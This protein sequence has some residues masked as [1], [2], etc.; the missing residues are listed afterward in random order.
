VRPLEAIDFRARDWIPHSGWPLEL[1]DLAPYYASA[2]AFLHLSPGAFDLQ[3]RTRAIELSPWSFDRDEVRSLV[4][5]IVD[6]KYRRFGDTLR[7]PV[8]AAPNIHTYLHANALALQPDPSGKR[9]AGVAT[10]TLSGRRLTARA[11]HYVLAAG[12]IENAR[13]LLLSTERGLGNENDL[14]GRFF[15]NHLEARVGQLVPAE[16]ERAGFYWKRPEGLGSYAALRLA[17]RIQTENKLANCRF[18]VWPAPL[19]ARN[20]LDRAIARTVATTDAR[21][22]EGRQKATRDRSLSPL[23]LHL[24]AEPAPNPDSRVT[25]GDERDAFDQRKVVLDWRLS[26]ADSTRVAQSL[27]RLALAVGASAVGRVHDLFPRDGFRS[28]DPRG[29]FHHM[30]T[31]RMHADAKR[32]VVDAQCRLHATANLHVAGSSV[33]PTFG[34][35]NPTLTILALAFRLADRLVELLAQ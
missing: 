12:G 14:V 32:G 5:R 33:F 22:V 1:A 17:D 34:T 9:I 4:V 6:E 2:L 21:S 28:A 7:E 8:Q 26:E 31:T 10:G 18:Q 11:R 27:D 29:S 24:V 20:R 35:A 30:G 15:G 13:L 25:L 19:R 23:D 16:P 3:A